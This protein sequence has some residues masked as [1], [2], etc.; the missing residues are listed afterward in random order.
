MARH[1]FDHFWILLV[2]ALP[3]FVIGQSNETIDSADWSLDLEDV[4]VTATYAPTNSRSAIHEVRVIDRV[5][6]ERLQARNLQQLLANDASIRIQEDRFLGSKTTLLGIGGQNVKIMVDGVPVIGRVDG[7]VDM[8]QIHL[9]D[10]EQVEIVEG[11][12]SVNYGT[13][14]L[15]GVI[16]IITKKSQLNRY[17]LTWDAANETKGERSTSLQLGVRPS[18]KWYLKLQGGM[19]RFDGWDPDSTRSSVWKPKAQNYASSTVRFLPNEKH[20]FKYSVKWLDESISNEGD[21]RRPQ[22]KPYAFD[23]EYHTRR[24]DHSIHYDGNYDNGLYLRSFVAYNT[25][26]RIVDAWRQDIETGDQTVLPADQD[27]SFISS[28]NWRTTLSSQRP[29][30]KFRYMVGLDLRYDDTEGGRIEGGD[31]LETYILD[32]AVFGSV[33]YSPIKS[34]TFESG[35]RYAVN[36]RYETPIIPSLNV[37]YQLNENWT[38]RASYGKGF[39]SPDIKE[40]FFNFV[41]VNHFII[42]NQ[43]IIPETSNNYQV[44]VTYYRFFRGQEITFGL[45]TFFNDISDK[46]DLF[47]YIDTPD[48][49]IPAV[50]TVTNTYTYFN[51]DKFRTAGVGLRFGYD[52]LRWKIRIGHNLTGQYNP[53]LTADF[54]EDNKYAFSNEISID[55]RYTIPWIEADINALIRYY[56][57]QITFYP[58]ENDQ[59]EAILGQRTQDGYTTLDIMLNRT[60]WDDRIRLSIGGRNLL[61]VRTTNVRG[62][63]DG[64]HAT[65][66]TQLILSPGRRLFA[67]LAFN[68]AWD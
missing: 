21:I 22:F 52:E 46:I 39:R 41:D 44:G 24:L 8:G 23:E 65:N 29:S 13:D 54:K 64:R 38:F 16:N 67:S 45:K 50:D 42:G 30:S 5:D 58:T 33:R 26:D 27:S 53:G 40:L 59:G 28:W 3:V 4:V 62:E 10:V 55:A 11:P 9:N 51:L 7:N 31:S 43:D 61:D 19:D 56:D 35:L 15:A 57:R 6:I 32:N 68:L 20:D 36:N 1:S 25:F 14:A 2:L 48:G 47:E 12:L 49:R 17:Q 18:K 37:R 63:E 66:A 60:F 34:L